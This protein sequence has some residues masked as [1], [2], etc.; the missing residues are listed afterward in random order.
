MKRTLS[1]LLA[2]SMLLATL[3]GCRNNEEM[4]KGSGQGS[5]SGQGEENENPS[6]FDEY[7][8]VAQD[9]FLVLDKSKEANIYGIALH[10]E[11]TY[12]IYEE[13]PEN[14]VP[15]EQADDPDTWFPFVRL[16]QVKAM[17][18]SGA[19]AE[20]LTIPESFAAASASLIG[21]HINDT[22][23]IIIVS[24]EYDYEN[25]HSIIIYERATIK[26]ELLQKEELLQ[27]EAMWADLFVHFE[28]NGCIAIIGADFHAFTEMNY[29]LHLWDETLSHMR[30]ETIFTSAFAFGRDGTYIHRTQN[31]EEDSKL[32]LQSVD[33]KTGE[34]IDKYP[35]TLERVTSIHL[36]E[37]N[38]P[39]DYYIVS[40]LWEQHLY[41][42]DF[43]TGEPEHILDFIE[44]N[45][46]LNQDLFGYYLFSLTDGAIAVSLPVWDRSS[47]L[48]MSIQY[49]LGIL[50]PVHRSVMEDR[51]EVILAVFYLGDAFSD[52]VLEHN[53]R[54]PAQQITLR[55]YSDYDKN[56]D[57]KQ[58]NKIESLHL[59]ILSGNAPDIVY[60]GSNYSDEIELKNALIAQNYLIDLY[61]FID[62]DPVLSREDFFPNILKSSEDKNGR[63]PFMYS[64]VII[65][66]MISVDPAIKKDNWTLDN[67]LTFME[68]S[69]K[70]GNMEP[71]GNRVTGI[72]FLTTMLELIGNDFIDF[73]KG[74]SYFNSENFIR[75]LELTKAIPLAPLEG[76]YDLYFQELYTGKQSVNIADFF[77]LEGWV[78]REYRMYGLPDDFKLD[79]EFIGVPGASG[80]IHNA[81]LPQA[82]GILESCK[83]KD[84]AW[85]FIRQ[86][87]LQ[88]AQM[89]EYVSI[90]KD[91]FERR[92][93]ETKLTAGEKEILR[94]MIS[95]ARIQKP[96]SGTVMMIIDEEVDAFLRGTR[97]AQD[98]ARIIQSRVSIYVSEQSG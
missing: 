53:R 32:I 92:L 39:F 64:R 61:P 7:I 70:A 85:Q 63:L 18:R 15:K 14:P 3:T 46:Y 22:G 66:T 89:V 77:F 91:D 1:A 87:L 98:A 13:F 65:S 24:R 27:V 55:W 60:L 45:I 5:G 12:Y 82:F 93:A 74:E 97:S 16:I 36:A 84:T 8:Y 83:N 78:T 67:F 23:E 58:G 51:P 44:V 25:N 10:G 57:Y 47:I 54:N 29:T 59:D 76:Y 34:P 33:L 81:R 20:S 62:A 42:L 38:S 6:I 40:I 28:K 31:D 17:D 50:S 69:I 41:G 90:R 52:Q 37:E 48:S 94:D 88:G 75:L 56:G 26:G 11:L 86:T 4:G 2:F 68:N 35:L 19:V 96:L 9:G 21:F 73:E 79:Y 72:D 71:L 80:G 49:E 43:E 30:V 95:T